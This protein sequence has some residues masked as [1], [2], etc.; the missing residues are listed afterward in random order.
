VP[1][2]SP[3]VTAPPPLAPPPAL[4]PLDQHNARLLANVHPPGWRNPR[5]RDRYHLVV[6]GAGTAGLVTAAGAA[7]LGARV[8]LVERHLMGGDCLNVGCVPSKA[9]I[10]AA[11]A[12]HETESAATRFGG[13]R[14]SGS[15]DFAAV[16]ERMRRIRADLSPVDSA[17]RF[18]DLGVDVF[19]GHARFTALDQVTVGDSQLL[20]RRAVI[21]T[22]ARAAVPAIPGLAEAGYY[23]NET[24]FSL[25]ER[26][27][28]LL[29]LGAGPIGCELAQAFVRLGSKVTILDQV[30]RVLSRDDSDAARIIETALR[31]DG[32]TLELGV[33]ARRVERTGNG[34]RIQFKRKTGMATV[35]GSTLLVAAG[36][37]PNVEDLG[38]EAAGVALDERGLKVDDRLR[39]SN[40][41]V[42]AI[43][44][45]CSRYQF[46]HVSDFHAR[47][48]I[49]NAL[50][51][52]RSKA[53]RL[54]IPWSTYTSPEVAQVGLTREEADRRGVKID[55]VTVPLSHVDRAVLAGE[56]D[57]FLRVHLRRGTDKLAGVTVVAPHAGE[58]ISEATLAMTHGLGLSAMGR[59]IHPYP[60]VAEAYRKAAD[61]RRR[62]KLTPLAK[63]ILGLWFRVFR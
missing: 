30:D 34:L 9:I 59:T 23:T 53:S 17:Q 52:G 51:F 38:L 13:P 15:G 50:F 47:L 57:G 63:R 37:A 10:S 60:T 25:T 58:L 18:T 29:V 56:T 26:P 43:G 35:E 42:Y 39:T 31:A 5:P 3:G 32:V 14:A 36:R 33:E 28:H 41:R 48:V 11:R 21:A 22:G 2:P 20:F 46:T 16:M 1:T 44:D 62:E 49:P 7:A 55:T 8:A 24:I 27:T 12:W 19:L 61:L 45:V 40:P 6:I 54:V 4:A